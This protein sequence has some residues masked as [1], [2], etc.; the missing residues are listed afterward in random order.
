MSS[1]TMKPLSSTTELQINVLN[2]VLFNFVL[3]HIVQ[4]LDYYDNEFV[5]TLRKLQT[6]ILIGT[7][8]LRIYLT[9][10]PLNNFY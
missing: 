10:T 4:Y 5:T 3:L 1:L 6:Y 8:Y 9:N 2:F 7:K